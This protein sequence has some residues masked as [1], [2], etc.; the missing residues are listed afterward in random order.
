[1]PMAAGLG[2]S[3]QAFVGADVGGFAGNCTA[4]L[5]LRW[6]QYGT[7]TPFCRN[8]SEIGNVDQYAWSWGEVIEN[9]VREAVRLRYRL[10]PYLYTAF[11]HAS[12]TGEPVQRPLVFDH[13]YDAVTSDLDD[14]YLFGTD[15]LVAPVTSPGATSRQVYLPSGDWYD[16][17]TDDLVAGQQFVIAPTPL[18]RLPVF[19]R[20]G[21]VVPLWPE[22]PPST[23]GYHPETIELHVFVPSTDGSYTSMLAED[24]GLTFALRD[25]FCYRTTFRLTRDGRRVALV[26][27]VEGNGYPEFRRQAFRLVVHGASPDA[28]QLD[29]DPVG[30]D[31]GGFL[32][33]NRG[34][35]FAAEFLVVQR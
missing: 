14:E 8:H 12:E 9:L 4:E 34:T 13:Q 25:G 1:M 35:G 24:D 18:D 15:L 17:H 28:V 32:L 10:L 29:G 19:A 11:V 7:L 6:M 31:E 3:G 22:A 16:W 27:T 26:A 33:P 5:Y 21:A 30:R 20:G 2:I 23:A